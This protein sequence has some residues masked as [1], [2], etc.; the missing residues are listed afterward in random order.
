MTIPY[1]IDD[2]EEDAPLLSDLRPAHIRSPSSSTL[3]FYQTRSRRIITL[4]IFAI[5]FIMAFGGTLMA[6][7]SIRL[8]EDIICHH[9][10]N[11]LKG[12]DHI[13]LGEEIEEGLCKRGE[14]QEQL[15]ILFAGLHFLGALPCEWCKRRR[16]GGMGLANW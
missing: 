4:I 8:Y 2:E 5:I 12:E 14:V 16:G 3:P 6:V 11:G 1:D 10:Y 9:F 7:P 13:G 15:N